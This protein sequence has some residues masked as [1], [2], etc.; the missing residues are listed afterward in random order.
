MAEPGRKGNPVTATKET[1]TMTLKSSP[2][3]ECIKKCPDGEAGINCRKTC[4]D[5]YTK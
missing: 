1:K 3:H 2:Y 5:K 4:K